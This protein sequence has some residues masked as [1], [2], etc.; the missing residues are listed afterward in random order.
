MPLATSLADADRMLEA[1]D[2]HGA[3]LSIDHT[4][5]WM[6]VWRHAAEQVIE[7]G[8][9]GEVRTITG[10]SSGARA[11]LFRNGHAY[12]RHDLLVGG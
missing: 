12:H 7:P 9:I 10:G 1:V 5:R 2:K 11:M 8:E 4:R 6:P 3:L